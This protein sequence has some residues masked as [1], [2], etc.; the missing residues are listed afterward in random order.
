MTNK[1]YKRH[2]LNIDYPQILL[3]NFPFLERTK[4]TKQAFLKIFKSC[5]IP[6]Y[7]FSLSKSQRMYKENLPSRFLVNTCIKA[8]DKYSES[9][10][11]FLKW[12][13][14]KGFQ[15]M[16]LRTFSYSHFSTLSNGMDL[17]DCIRKY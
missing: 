9:I 3:M 15:H 5:G 7:F 14:S 8:Y 6:L 16:K 1:T 4:Y 13:V 17:I 10:K 11:L 12:I 2:F